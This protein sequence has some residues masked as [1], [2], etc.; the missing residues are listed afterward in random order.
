MRSANEVEILPEKKPIMAA[1]A[2]GETAAWA[3]GV[4]LERRQQPKKKALANAAA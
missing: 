3:R 4:L 2:S 1:A